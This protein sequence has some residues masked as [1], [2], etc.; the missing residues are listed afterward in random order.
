SKFRV[1]TSGAAHDQHSRPRALKESV[2]EIREV[3]SFLSEIV[4]TAEA[5]ISGDPRSRSDFPQRTIQAADHKS[6][7]D[8][9]ATIQTPTHSNQT[10]A[11]PAY[12]S[13]S[14]L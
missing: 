6:V 13:L 10:L 9:G 14:V 3:E 12:R 1:R 11:A 7:A 8:I 5:L 4:D 2:K